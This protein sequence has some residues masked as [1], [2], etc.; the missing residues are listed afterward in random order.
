[1][2]ALTIKVVRYATR[3][4]HGGFHAHGSTRF[5]IGADGTI[6]RQRFY[7]RSFACV[8]GEPLNDGD[9]VLTDRAVHVNCEELIA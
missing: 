5:V 4:R 1:M 7:G 2:D 3:R 6:E 9:R 8:C